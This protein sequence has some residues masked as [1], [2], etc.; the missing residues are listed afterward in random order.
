MHGL[1]PLKNQDALFGTMVTKQ[2]TAS[3][4]AAVSL[5]H[6]VK[7]REGRGRYALGAV[8]KLNGLSGAEV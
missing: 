1:D 8:H 7:D 5:D 3:G 4:A 2:L 6:V